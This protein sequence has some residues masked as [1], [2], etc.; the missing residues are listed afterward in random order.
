[1][2][3]FISQLAPAFEIN[4]GCLNLFLG[5]DIPKFDGGSI[6]GNQYAYAQKILARINMDCANIKSTPSDISYVADD[7][8]N[9]LIGKKNLY[10][11]AIGSL[12]YTL[13][14]Q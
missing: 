12:M 7:E 4:T 9:N 10:L 11:Q 1:M 2:G 3:E 5:M 14:L 6:F 8:E 13:L